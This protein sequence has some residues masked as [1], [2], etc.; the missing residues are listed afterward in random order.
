MKNAVTRHRT[1][2][3][4]FME[5]GNTAAG[6]PSQKEILLQTTGS[7]LGFIYVQTGRERFRALAAARDNRSRQTARQT[8]RARSSPIAHRQGRGARPALSDPGARQGV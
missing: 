2:K 8:E 1:R 6:H 5:G 4:T 7:L 3:R